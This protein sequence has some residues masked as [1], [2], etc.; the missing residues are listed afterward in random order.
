[1]QDQRGSIW[2]K[3]DLHIHSPLKNESDFPVFIQNL[4]SSPVE[5]IGINDY[6]SINGYKKVKEIGGLSKPYFPVVEF[7]MN[8]IV[9]NKN[10][11]R[12][13]R[14]NF[15][16][17]FN[18]DDT[19]LP[20]IETWLNSLQCLYEGG[21]TVLFGS[22]P[23][24]DYEKIQF[25][26]F[27][28]IESLKSN[29]LD[30][31]SLVWLPYNEYGGIDN[32]DPINDPYYKLGLIKEAHII[33]SSTNSISD[34]FSWKNKKF[35]EE[36]YQ[37]WLGM[38]KPCIKGSDS[39]QIDYIF[40]KLRNERSEPIEKFCWIKADANFD[41]LK[42]IVNEPDRVFI[43]LK[44]NGIEV[45][46]NNPT[47][48]IERISIKKKNQSSL[49]EQ[50]FDGL[51]IPLN[52]SL[53][54]IIGN[55]GNG[56]SALADILGLCG[57]TH[58]YNVFSFLND[59]KF[60]KIRD[61]KA[62]HF[63][64]T[65]TWRN[66]QESTRNLSDVP[67]KN[68]KEKVKYLPQSYLET[69]CVDAESSDFEI[70]L[71]KIIFSRIPQELRL[72]KNSLDELI[73]H[74]TQIIREDIEKIKAEIGFV[75]IDISNLLVKK[76][77]EY[78]QQLQDSL[79]IKQEELDAH[80][81]NKPSVVE[82]PVLSTADSSIQKTIDELRESFETNKQLIESKTDTLNLL[83]IS[84]EELSQQLDYFNSLQVSLDKI[85]STRKELLEK[86]EIKIEQVFTYKIDI[87]EIEAKLK[88]VSDD[89]SLIKSELY[90]KDGL[91][92]K[93]QDTLS[94]LKLNQEKLEE[95]SKIYQKYLDTLLS[96]NKT[97]QDII[98][99]KNIEGTI[100]NI[101]D[102]ILYLE[103]TLNTELQAKYLLRRD[104]VTTLFQKKKEIL[105]N[106]KELYSPIT[107][108]FLQEHQELTKT[109][110][111]RFDTSFKNDGFFER[112]EGF[113][114]FN[115][116]GSF[117][118]REDGL[119]KIKLIFETHD[120]NKEDG[121]LDFL[122]EVFENLEYD[123]RQNQ[124]NEYRNIK[125]QLKSSIKPQDLLNYLCELDYL[126]PIYELKLYD[127]DVSSLSP[128]ERGALLL[129]FYLL[130][131]NDTIPLII[132][133][134]EENLD[135]QSIYSILVHFIKQAKIKRQI[136]IVTHNPNLAVVCDAEQII[137]MHIDK[138][139]KNEVSY[140]S[141]AIE[142]RDIN[143]KIIEV[144]EGTR[145]AFSNRTLK[146]KISMI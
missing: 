39:H 56:K 59:K 89:I 104:L 57:N 113:I 112:F 82:A 109:Y 121:I 24:E 30:T 72:N 128:G 67:D 15:H 123:K 65:I 94:A 10:S 105:E 68:Q 2:R 134:P 107:D 40:G 116:K 81:K 77:P 130:L 23:F 125:N 119:S 27:K 98:G 101:K 20:T 34:Y 54:A 126:E 4:N 140:I 75:N 139:N 18:N 35:T 3:W 96:W 74:K 33:G 142:N 46:E 7:R 124:N 63:D 64:A 145:P 79:K 84:S 66:G 133:Q 44:P 32:I 52:T 6:C 117:Y 16:I 120:L 127:K 60:K 43:G 95:P 38:P 62:Q 73:E 85:K 31:N 14:I 93:Q 118:N 108:F 36:Q 80:I 87:S 21:K 106:Y 51:D 110:K 28:V 91:Q 17:I 137:Y 29:S 58:N 78:K 131:D 83:S 102:A 19:L 129:I 86:H 12:G 70:E 41:G 111:I 25:D 122:D 103:N 76:S 90:G 50:W 11:D 88:K 49:Q 146:Y 48:F 47:K 99:G 143:K 26:Y 1:M 42:Q 13:A 138:E 136:I 8:N 144:L 135:N 61:N 45:V 71:R 100:E 97:H 92:T 37:E 132:D 141:G 114:N 22:V 9:T 69:I 53:V 5:V 115:N 55:K